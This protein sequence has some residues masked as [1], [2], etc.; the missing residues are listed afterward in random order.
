MN[1]AII[2]LALAALPLGLYNLILLHKDSSWKYYIGI[3]GSAWSFSGTFLIYLGFPGIAFFP[4]LLGILLLGYIMRMKVDRSR[5]LVGKI[6]AVLS[7]LV[8]IL[9]GLLIL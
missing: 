4:V 6:A 2:L 5:I 1:P 7:L 9:V 8:L 3:T